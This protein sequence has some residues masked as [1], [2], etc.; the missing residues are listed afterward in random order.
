F[1][2]TI[3]SVLY[4][5]EERQFDVHFHPL[6]DCATSLLSDPHIGPC[7]VFDAERLY[8]Y[9]GNQFEQFIDEPWTA[10]AFLNAQGKPLAF[11]LYS[12]KTKLLTFGTAK[13]YP[14]VAQLT[15]LP[16]DI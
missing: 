1:E 16:V 9:N 7:A 11:I 2:Q 6:W 13:A 3:I 8:K 14:V 15:N 4:R 12:D 5:K 10:D